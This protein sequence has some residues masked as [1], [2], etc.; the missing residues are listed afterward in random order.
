MNISHT[1][2]AKMPYHREL[3]CPSHFHI[4]A[5]CFLCSTPLGGGC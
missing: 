2:F 5:K 1:R 4:I 3:A